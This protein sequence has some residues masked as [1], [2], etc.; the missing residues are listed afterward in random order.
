MREGA[1][2]TDVHG[3]GAAVYNH[4]CLSNSPPEPT[5]LAANHHVFR[6]VDGL[7]QSSLPGGEVGRCVVRR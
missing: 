3:E 4:G 6:A 5:E 1:S 2:V 7:Q